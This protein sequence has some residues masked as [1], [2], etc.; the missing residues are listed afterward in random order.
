MKLEGLPP[1]ERPA[2]IKK[3]AR[4]WRLFGQYLAKM[5]YGKCWY[6]ESDDPQAFF[7]VDHFRPKAEAKR[8]DGSV[9]EGYPWLAFS[10]QN[11]RYAAGRSNRLSTDEK[12]EVV[13]GKG[14]WFPLMEGSAQATWDERCEADER[15][16]LLDPTVKADVDLI[17]V[18][19]DGSMACSSL[20]MGSAKERVKSSIELYGLDL[21]KVS[22]AR[23]AVMREVIDLHTSLLDVLVAANEH[24]E[25][26]DK[27]PVPRQIAQLRRAT[28]P[29]A[30][31][32]RAARA[33][34]LMLGGASFCASPEDLP[35]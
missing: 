35:I 6:S 32:S 25:A 33:Q 7:D 9:D 10:W 3:N 30:R 26:A 8:A 4:L 27:L 20:C 34:L 18:N 19:A 5:S 17:D 11:F 2:F 21:P 13:V 28:M 24:P 23:R 1:A 31:F 29:T 15:P 16:R 12:A 22:S 14:S